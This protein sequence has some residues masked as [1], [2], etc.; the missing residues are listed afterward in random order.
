MSSEKKK[1]RIVESSNGSTRSVVISGSSKESKKIKRSSDHSQN[2]QQVH[3]EEMEVELR[4]SQK[5]LEFFK[6][7][8]QDLRNI[9][10]D[11]Y[12]MKTGSA[13]DVT[14]KITA[15]RMEAVLHFIALKKL[16][17]LAHIRNKKARD[18][19]EEAKEKVDSFHLQLQNLLYEVMHLQKEVTKCLEFKS[20]DEDIDLVNLNDFY[21]EAPEDISKPCITKA[22]SHQQRLARLD[23]ELE[24]RKSLSEKYKEFQEK[25]N[26]IVKEIEQKKE[27]LDSLQPMLNTILQSTVPVQEYL[28][29]PLECIRSQHRIAKLLPRPLYILYVQA[30]AYHE[31]CDE[32]IS[33]KIVGDTEGALSQET[34]TPE[35][36]YDS[37]SDNEE[38]AS[39]SKRRRKTAGNKMEERRQK[40]LK[41]HPLAVVM[42]IKCKDDV[43]LTLTFSYLSILQI[44]TVLI[45]LKCNITP[46][47][48]RLKSLS[49]YISVIG[50]PYRWVQHLCGLD[51]LEEEGVRREMK[52]ASSVCVSY[53]ESTITALKRRITARL[54][55]NKQLTA[56]E[57]RNITVPS[58]CQSLFPTK[59]SSKL[60][61]WKPLTTEDFRTLPFTQD[62]KEFQTESNV[63]FMATIERGSARL[64]AAVILD[65]D[66]PIKTPYFI[67][68]LSWKGEQSAGNNNAIKDM[69]SE[70]NVFYKELGIEKSHNF[71]LSNQLQR[72]LMCLD[73]Y[74]ETESA[75]KGKEGPVEFA[76]EKMFPRLSRGRDRRKPYKYM[77]KFGYFCFRVETS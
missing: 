32:S 1:R 25:K 42:T 7:T 16:N 41:K 65:Q 75:V 10:K 34:T 66:Y 62:F 33:L 13:A 6:S 36:D 29:M 57:R 59:I 44:A 43:I 40:T 52:P 67:L 63:F 46:A 50:H 22:D 26:V 71:I 20:T 68:K 56:L 49:S 8:C 69:E 3:S 37:D 54:A 55:L 73:V 31:A 27:Y 17:R 64:Q 30:N 74:L 70:V 48:S 51:F 11:V 4:D 58:D 23:W 14:E 77:N 47:N 5:D 28:A 53:I 39:K 76:K 2:Q 12:E 35:L 21:Q 38:A 72:L 60:V 19:T 9:M 61:S 18:S 24:Q 45:D 15:K